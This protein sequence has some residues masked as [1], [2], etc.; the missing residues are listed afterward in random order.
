MPEWK[1]TYA[2]IGIAEFYAEN[3]NECVNITNRDK[4]EGEEI[5][6]IELKK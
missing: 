4:R 3:I 2:T 1:I 6:K 5:L